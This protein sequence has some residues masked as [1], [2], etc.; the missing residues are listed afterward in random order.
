MSKSGEK[1]GLK[2]E[3]SSSTEDRPMENLKHSA[4]DKASRSTVSKSL[5]TGTFSELMVS[6]SDPVLASFP[7]FLFL[8]FLWASSND[9]SQK[10]GTRGW[11]TTVLIQCSYNVLLLC[12]IYWREFH[13]QIWMWRCLFFFWRNTIQKFLYSPQSCI[14][15]D[16]MHEQMPSGQKVIHHLQSIFGQ[17]VKEFTHWVIPW[18]SYHSGSG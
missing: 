14:A 1:T 3:L 15:L 11:W 7:F 6:K 10:T 9:H 16:Q 12:W 5:L 8:F 4:P 2:N 17:W 18:W 13:R